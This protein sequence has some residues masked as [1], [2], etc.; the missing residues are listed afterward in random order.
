MT[1]VSRKTLTE[2]ARKHPDLEVP[3]DVW[4][5]TAKSAKWRS[6]DEIRKT[7]A[8]AD[9]VKGRTVF[10]IKGN[11]YRLIVGIQHESQAIF[12]EHVLTHAEY[13]KGDWK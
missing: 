11:N 10:N 2:A 4:Y 7:W 8:N 5:R 12:I 1:I 3:L 9:C 13:N 6:L